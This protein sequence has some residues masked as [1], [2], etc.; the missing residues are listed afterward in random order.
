MCLNMDTTLEGLKET[1]TSTQFICIIS[2]FNYLKKNTFKKKGLI[3]LTFI[4][5][6]SY[7]YIYYTSKSIGSTSKEKRKKKEKVISL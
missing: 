2:Y 1:W 3:K 6:K 5:K 4:I 7:I